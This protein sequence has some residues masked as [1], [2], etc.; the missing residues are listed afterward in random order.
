MNTE[1][2]R[3]VVACIKRL[4]KEHYLGNISAADIDCWVKNFP[5][6]STLPYVLL[7][8]LVI[9][10]DDQKRACV[11]Y[12]YRNIQADY[13]QENMEKSDEQLT[14]GFSQYLKDTAF[15]CAAYGGD[16][17]SSAAQ[18]MLELRELL[19]NGYQEYN[20]HELCAAI[21]E[22]RIKRVYLVDDF[23][24]TG[25][26]MKT[27]IAG[28]K[29]TIRCIHDKDKLCCL[30][31]LIRDYPEVKFGIFAIVICKKGQGEILE[32][33]PNMHFNNAYFLDDEYDLLHEQCLAYRSIQDSPQKREQISACVQE[34]EAIRKAFGM[35]NDYSLHLP[36][37]FEKTFPNNALELFWWN[38]HGNWKP[39][40]SRPEDR[41]P[42]V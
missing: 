35:D 15:V 33:Y 11:E 26:Q 24:G 29:A 14:T 21:R 13:Y 25:T 10:N 36:C 31:C 12:L 23:V 6:D 7:N 8:S 17:A 22:K 42:A 34:I 30:E 16:T 40:L 37:G 39:L 18:I 2:N 3:Q 4:A 20:E 19:G 1:Q 38:R 32:E 5:A 27:F 41:N 9:I 28:K